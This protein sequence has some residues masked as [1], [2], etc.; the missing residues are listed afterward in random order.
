MVVLLPLLAAHQGAIAG[1][2]ALQLLL[3]HLRTPP[4]QACMLMAPSACYVCVRAWA[5]CYASLAAPSLNGTGCV[6]GRARPA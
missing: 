3:A 5:P 1:L 2:V 4:R 6:F